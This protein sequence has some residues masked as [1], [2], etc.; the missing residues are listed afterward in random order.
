M[1]TFGPLYGGREAAELGGGER[2]GAPVR[3]NAR[4]RET[5]LVHEAEVGADRAYWRTI[6]AYLPLLAVPT[7]L[8]TMRRR[9]GLGR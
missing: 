6:L 1:L 8:R 9:V 5:R 2:L 4:G 3:G 7:A